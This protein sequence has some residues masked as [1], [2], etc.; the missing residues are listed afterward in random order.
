MPT[1]QLRYQIHSGKDVGISIIQSMRIIASYATLGLPW[2]LRCKE[3]ACGAGNLLW[4][5]GQ[6][7]P[8]RRAWQPSPVFLP[9]ESPW[10]GEFG[11]LQSM[12]LQR[13]GH[14]WVTSTHML[15]YDHVR[16]PLLC[17]SINWK[18]NPGIYKVSFLFIA[19]LCK[20][21]IYSLIK[22]F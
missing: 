10:V 4:S 14:N 9:R 16:V 7:N 20:P 21:C 13:V 3:S 18:K 5:L 1:H 17:N 11:G 19:F 2:W 22:F 6:E 15:P 12:G 8:W